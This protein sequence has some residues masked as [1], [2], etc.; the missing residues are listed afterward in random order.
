MFLSAV[1]CNENTD[2][3]INNDAEFDTN[4]TASGFYIQKFP[5]V[6]QLI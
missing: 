1:A 5:I 3:I 6:L 2:I 4:M